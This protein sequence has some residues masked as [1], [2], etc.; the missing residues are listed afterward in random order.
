MFDIKAKV[1]VYGIRLQ[2]KAIYMDCNLDKFK[3]ADNCSN[4]DKD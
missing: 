2:V 1:R 3:Q 4:L